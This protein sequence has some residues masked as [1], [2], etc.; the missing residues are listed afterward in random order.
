MKQ[1]TLK[2]NCY[3]TGIYD[4]FRISGKSSFFH[5]LITKGNPLD[6]LNTL[7]EKKRSKSLFS[8][9]N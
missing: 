6:I 5:N 2:K 7:D 3:N 1:K 9:K 4:K 8:N